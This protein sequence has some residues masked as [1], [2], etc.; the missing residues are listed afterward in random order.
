MVLYCAADLLWATRIKATADSLG[1]PCRPARSVEMLKARLAD[2]DTRALI[3]DLD[4]AESSLA[5]LAALRGSAESPGLDPG[6][7]VRV[8]A[9]GPHVAVELFERARAAG[10]D[11]VLARGAFDRRLPEILSA[12][13][14]GAGEQR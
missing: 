13:N 2:S 14:G 8:L 6:R 4:A 7:K 12:L 11:E 1:I 9:F 10:A 5:L 3:L